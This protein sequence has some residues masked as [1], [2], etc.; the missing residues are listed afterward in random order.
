M[1]FYIKSYYYKFMNVQQI[2]KEYYDGWLKSDLAKVKMLLCHDLKFRSPEDDFDD[3]KSFLD[4]CWKFSENFDTMNIE[5]AVYDKDSAYLVYGSNEFYC[6][7]LI[8]IKDSKISE[9]YVT[10]APTR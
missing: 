4:S 1:L 6:G 5:H 10:F 3:A 2:I 8:K 9:I 7:E